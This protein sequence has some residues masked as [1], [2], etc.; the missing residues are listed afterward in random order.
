MTDCVIS[1]KAKTYLT[2][3]LNESKRVLIKKKRKR[4][5]LKGIYYTTTISSII[6]SAIT[7]VTITGLP[8]VAATIL[9]IF[10]AILTGLS[11]QFNF[12]DRQEKINKEVKKYNLIK[13]KLDYVVNCNGDLTDEIWNGLLKELATY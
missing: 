4:N 7:A 11:I 8:M 12:K 10:S 3:K 1:N 6:L 5:I 9:P 13:S 2:A